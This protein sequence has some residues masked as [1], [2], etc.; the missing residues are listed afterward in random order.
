MNTFEY[1]RPESKQGDP[2]DNPGGRVLF[3]F[4]PDSLGVPTGEI[5]ISSIGSEGNMQ[6]VLGVDVDA[7]LHFVAK[8]IGSSRVRAIEDREKRLLES[9]TSGIREDG[10][11]FWSY[12]DSESGER[13]T[14]TSEDEFTMRGHEKRTDTVHESRWRVDG[15]GDG[16]NI[17]VR[18]GLVRCVAV[19][20]GS[21]ADM[22]TDKLEYYEPGDVIDLLEGYVASW[23]MYAK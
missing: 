7:I 12:Y 23:V 6:G 5:S 8:N 13:I 22:H 20:P 11:R 21:Y 9:P 17:I 1:E 4:E 16:H 10:V 18:G 15:P 19:A 3:E 14:L 2:S